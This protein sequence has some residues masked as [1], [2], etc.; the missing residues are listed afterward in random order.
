MSYVSTRSPAALVFVFSLLACSPAAPPAPPALVPVATASASPAPSVSPV[1]LGPKAPVAPRRPQST[2]IHGLTRVDDYFWLRDK[3]TPD[4]LGYLAAENAYTDAMAKP[5]E[6]LASSLYDEMLARVQQDDA[7]PPFKEGAYLYYSRFETGK[8]YPIHC[9]RRAGVKAAPEEVLLDLNVLGATEKFISVPDR[10]VSD[11]GN[12]LAYLVDTEGFRQFTLKVKDLRTGKTGSEAIPRVDGVVFAKDSRTVFYLTEDAQTKRPNKLFRHTLGQP[13][14]RD[15]L[16]Y[17]EADE[18]FDLD[19]GR[20]LDRQVITVTSESKTTSEVR[21]LDAARP[22]APA[23]L[24]APREHDHKYFVDHRGDLF[25]IRTNSGG[26]NFRLV[27]VKAADPR[28]ETWKELVPHRQDVMLENDI[29][30]ADHMILVERHDALPV[31]TVLDYRTAK[32]TTLEQPEGTYSVEPEENHEF[33]AKTFRYTYESLRTPETVVEYDLASKARTV[34]KTTRVIGYD[35]DSYETKRVSVPARDGT[36]IPVSLVYRKG[37]TPDG[38]HPMHLNAY[39]SYGISIPLSFSSTRVSLLDRGFVF[40]LAHIRGGGDNGKRWHDEGRMMT[41][42]NTFTDFIDVAIAMKE[43][44]WA[45]KDALV[46]SGA[47]AGGMLMG[48]VTNMR[49]DLFRVVLAY[50]PFVDVVNTMLDESLPLTVGE[51]EEW[52]NP[53]Q[54]DAYDTMMKYSPYDNV[55]AQA[56]PAMLVRTSYNDS[57]VMYWEPSKYVAK[58][59]ATRTND[60][61][62]LF[63]VNMQPAGHGGQSG[64]FD[65]L[66]DTAWDYA[67][68][69]SQL[70]PC[71]K[72]H[73]SCLGA[74]AGLYC[75]ADT[76][77]KVMSCRGPGGCTTAGGKTTC[78]NDI[79]APADGCSTESDGACT[80]DRATLLKCTGERFEV[81]DT[82]KGPGACAVVA[83]HLLCDNDVADVGD[84]CSNTGNFACASDHKV[85]LECKDKRYQIIQSCRGPKACTVVRKTPDVRDIDCDLT[86]A[87]EHDPCAFAGSQAC[88]VDG[89]TKLTCVAG[90]YGSPVACV[91]PKGCVPLPGVRVEKVTCDGPGAPTARPAHR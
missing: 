54:R 39:G 22:T 61:P 73:T 11:D 15:A 72:D 38:T 55:K 86:R 44:G 77:N 50:V 64:R 74:S 10:V 33:T 70:G 36:P 78:D 75:S 68:A 2:T 4:V 52:G 82:C 8:Q 6:P 1:A 46:I 12:T 45:K 23:R 21:V 59:R 26:R 57:Q 20:T 29:A 3:G 30:F 5:F 83:D 9:R 53:K 17:E 67:F 19:V 18:M 60:A 34:L 42:M 63:K 41:K 84:P 65:R 31:L 81:I 13:A 88:S 79:A 16:V 35:P 48:G 14:T 62:L 85:A 7:S 90:H 47:S 69:L 91:G 24:V 51:F 25:Y 56:Y 76:T 87:K 49:P 37:T 80:A 40:A 27:T 43:Q 89:K 28:R 71:V 58:L 32:E 66:R